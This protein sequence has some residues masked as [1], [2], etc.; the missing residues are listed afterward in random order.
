MK[1]KWTIVAIFSVFLVASSILTVLAQDVHK[2]NSQDVQNAVVMDEKQ[3]EKQEERSCDEIYRDVKAT[4][5]VKENLFLN[6]LNGVDYY[7]TVQGTFRTTF[8]DPEME[9]T[10]SYSVDI[11]NQL[12]WEEAVN[13]SMDIVSYY[14][15]E[16]YVETDERQRT[17]AQYAAAS[18]PDL[19]KRERKTTDIYEYASVLEYRN[20]EGKDVSRER[21]GKN[22]SGEMEYYYRNDLTNAHWAATSLF[23]QDLIFGF[24]TDLDSWDIIGVEDFLGRQVVVISGSTADAG[25]AEK[26]N[27]A[28]FEMRFD[29][30]SGILMD[31]EGYAANGELSQYLKTE[32]ISI[33]APDDNLKEYIADV[34]SEIPE[35]YSVTE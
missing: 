28:T 31:F 4:N 30:E 13:D 10:V 2:G 7:D 27:C 5:Q 32:E 20:Y 25:Y 17:Y 19:K 9:T 12:A 29:I 21:V 16:V 11:P 8:I 34:I 15:D 18:H 33:D 35:D 26:L 23:S 14:Q 24:L 22:A 1:T 3:Q 6:L